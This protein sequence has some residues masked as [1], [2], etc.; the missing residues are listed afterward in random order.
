MNQSVSG[1][2]YPTLRVSMEYFLRGVEVLSQVHDDV[3]SSLIFVTLWHGQMQ[4]SGGALVGVRE[5]SRQ[6]G[7]PYETVRRHARML[8]RGGQCIEEKGGLA[9][10]A[11]MMRSPRTATMLRKSYVNAAR[12]LRDLTRIGVARFSIDANR[13]LRSGRLTKEQTII[14]IAGMGML[15]KGYRALR[16]FANGDF[17]KG[18]V[19]TTIW[20]AN[21]KH[22]TNTPTAGDRG[23]LEDSQRLPVSVLAV[24][25]ALRLPYETVRRHANA[26]LKDGLCMRLGRRGLVVQART[27]RR[28]V[29]TTQTAH[30]IVTAFLAELRKAG[31]SV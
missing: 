22:V 9:V 2:A 25:S 30:R 28:N 31:I 23:I 16:E 3:V 19:F 4:R 26:L 21:V 14:G 27:H 1:D 24:S 5:L 15:L 13:P 11:A 20:T 10:P 7:L 18:L 12:V 17:I 29:A 6:L 8:V